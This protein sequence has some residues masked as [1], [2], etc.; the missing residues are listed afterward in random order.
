MV[1]TRAE[2]L[3]LMAEPNGAHALLSQSCLPAGLST[4]AD[5]TVSHSS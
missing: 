3:A 2:R 4:N 5:V 1:A